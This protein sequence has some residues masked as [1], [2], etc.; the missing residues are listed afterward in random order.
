[1]VA[2]SVEFAQWARG[3]HVVWAIEWVNVRP[4]EAGETR[5]NV[6]ASVGECG[7]IYG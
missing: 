1:M 3:Q 7:R 6:W 4:Q 5:P 2:G